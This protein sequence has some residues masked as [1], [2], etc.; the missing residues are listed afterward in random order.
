M[1]LPFLYSVEREYSTSIEN[2][3]K[4]WVEPAALAA[5]Y[6]PT[7][8]SV[9]A[10]SVENAAEVGGVWAVG[11]DVPAYGFVAYFYGTYTEVIEHQKL[12]HTMSYTQD[13][14]EFEAR[15]AAPTH[16]VVIE[17]ET[18]GDKSWVKFSQFGQL[19]EGQDPSQP[20]A[21]M[22]SYFNNL[23]KYLGV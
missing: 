10:G 3:W 1:T 15:V 17:F 9:A 6:S 4:A 8:L 7:D 19:P 14:A 13:A 22:E 16:D 5:W 12:V 23:G 11:V 20:K 2:L 18:R 21:G